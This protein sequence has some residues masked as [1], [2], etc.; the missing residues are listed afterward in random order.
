M[1]IRKSDRVIGK[2]VNPLPK[3]DL[4]RQALECETA[5]RVGEKT[6]RQK[7]K[8]GIIALNLLS[9]YIM[10]MSL[11]INNLCKTYIVVRNSKPFRR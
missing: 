8:K 10:I 4:L 11:E 6:K 5:R 9:S 2:W 7:G 1:E 3:C